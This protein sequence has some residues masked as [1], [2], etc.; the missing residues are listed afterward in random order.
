VEYR[1]LLDVMSS[2]VPAA[3]CVMDIRTFTGTESSF[4]SHRAILDRRSQNLVAVAAP[5][6][7]VLIS[8]VFTCTV[9][10]M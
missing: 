10:I 4:D 9:A 8:T 7:H 5:E 2:G 3:G 6:A 1:Y